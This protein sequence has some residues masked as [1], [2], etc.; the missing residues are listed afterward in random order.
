MTQY[1]AFILRGLTSDSA[2]RYYDLNESQESS[3]ETLALSLSSTTSSP[4][5]QQL[6]LHQLLK[7]LFLRRL[8]EEGHDFKESLPSFVWFRHFK[9]G[10]QFDT[11]HQMARTFT[12]FA[13]IIKMIALRELLLDGLGPER[14]AINLLEMFVKQAQPTPYGWCRGTN[15]QVSA[16]VMSQNGR[17]IITMLSDDGEF[18]QYR[19]KVHSHADAPLM[20]QA[21]FAK[22]ENLLLEIFQ[23]ARMG[24]AELPKHTVITDRLREESM[25][26][27]AFDDPRNPF[28]GTR[29]NFLKGLSENPKYCKVCGKENVW[30]LINVR[31]LLQKIF[32]FTRLFATLE[33]LTSP[34][35]PRAT[36]LLKSFYR[37][38]SGRLRNLSFISNIAVVFAEYCKNSCRTGT[39]KTRPHGLPRRMGVMV[40][41]WL[42]MLRPAEAYLTPMIHPDIPLDVIHTESAHRTFFSGGRAILPKDIS[43]EL[44]WWTWYYLGERYGVASMR[45]FLVHTIREK[46]DNHSLV[47]V[48]KKR[49][50]NGSATEELAAHNTER[51]ATTYAI[52]HNTKGAMTHSEILAYLTISDVYH[53]HMGVKGG[54]VFH[55]LGEPTPALNT[56]SNSR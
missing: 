39:E 2:T 13:H 49:I 50:A 36:E 21:M 23:E 10:E 47:E 15:S 11:S 5:Q 22:A 46:V 31:I 56:G 6:L 16:D 7:C 25:R 18:F 14:L 48:A 30:D 54:E 9:D 8:E 28:K 3:A 52:A 51:G 43:Y 42:G 34:G 37:N 24:A 38:P 20:V 35:P 44:A 53:E 4:I 41:W 33:Y 1:L 40:I 19:E 55:P 27:S 26:Y 45:H 17:P 29:W 32:L 12:H